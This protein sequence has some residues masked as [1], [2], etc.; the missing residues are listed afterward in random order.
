MKEEIKKWFKKAEQDLDSA[1]YNFKGKK[2]DVGAFLCQ[3]SSEKALK[4][5]L[6]KKT[7]KIRKIHD[8]VELGRAVGLPSGLLD[9]AK[10]LTLSY[11]YARYPDTPEVKN[12]KEIVKKFLKVSKNII[13]WVE[14]Q[15]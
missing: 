13:K 4:A 3:Q 8:L 7:G 2:Y 12:L 14:E 5:L 15:L 11:V 9:S 10:E 6:L 1:K